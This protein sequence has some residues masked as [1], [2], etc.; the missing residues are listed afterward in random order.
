MPKSLKKGE[1]ASFEYEVKNYE[2]TQQ[3]A[4]HEACNCNNSSKG[5]HIHLI[6]NNK[7][8]KALY[9]PEFDTAL[10]PGH[11]LAVSFLSRSF[12]ESVKN[13]NAYQVEQFNVLDK[14][15]NDKGKEKEVD[16]SKPMLVYSRPKGEYS[17]KDAENVLLDFY[18]LNTDLSEAGNKVVATVNGQKFT[19]TK[20]TGYAIKGLKEGKNT[21]KLQLV[22]K[23]G[24]TIPGPYNSVERKITIKK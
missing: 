3:T 18:L 21:I 19:L 10:K 9:K 14:K 23:D 5:Q 8:Y 22:N 2:L 13:K 7:P 6:L 12:H 24:K 16:V 20:W 4:G 11:Y 15:G 1:K 17:G